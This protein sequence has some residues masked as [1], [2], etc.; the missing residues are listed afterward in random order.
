MTAVE[1]RPT[2]SRTSPASRR[3]GY[4]IAVAVNTLILYLINIWPGWDAFSFLTDD[5]VRVL[6]LVNVSLVVSAAVNVLY[7]VYD[8]R[9]FVALGGLVT[10]GV[11]LVVLTRIWQVFPFAFSSDFNW[12]LVVRVLLVL[13][14][15][16]SGIALIVQSVQLVAGLTWAR[17]GRSDERAP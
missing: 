3:V 2:R 14:M 9:W 1:R 11:G 16:G 15:V 8:A 7:L 13:A 6:Y 5:F 17:A 12:A 4:A 10:T